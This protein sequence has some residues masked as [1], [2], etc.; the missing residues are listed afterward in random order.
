M[1]NMTASIEPLMS[2]DVMVLGQM[3]LTRAFRSLEAPA[4]CSRRLGKIAYH[5]GAEQPR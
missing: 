1:K 5:E 2:R 3:K 4:S